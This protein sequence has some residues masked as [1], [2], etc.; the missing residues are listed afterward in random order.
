MESGAGT[1]G[2]VLLG[3]VG[4]AAVVAAFIL[5]VATARQTLAH[6]VIPKR[7]E[8]GVMAY[9]KFLN[10][11]VVPSLSWILASMLS[12]VFG[13]ILVKGMLF[14]ETSYDFLSGLMVLV[15]VMLADCHPCWT[16]EAGLYHKNLQE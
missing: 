1:I 9:I 6:L 15:G 12:F 11:L 8:Y 5:L 10:D 3:I 16:T 2:V 13:L 14:V 4:V 7:S